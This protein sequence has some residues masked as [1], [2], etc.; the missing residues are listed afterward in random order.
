MRKFIS[1]AALAAA[2]LA[3][4]FAQVTAATVQDTKTL[5]VQVS[6]ASSCSITAL[7]NVVFPTVSGTF[8]TETANGSLTVKCAGNTYTVSADAGANPATEG[9]VTTRRLKHGTS[10]FLPYDLFTTG[11]TEWGDG[12]GATGTFGAAGTAAGET[13]TILGSLPGAT[14][15]NPGVY[16]DLVVVSL[17][18]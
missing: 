6:V 8:T 7:S 5:N 14:N 18:F 13:Y 2:A 9:D 11:T 16:S 12:T 3:L 4:G 1:R 15:P 17:S 10:D